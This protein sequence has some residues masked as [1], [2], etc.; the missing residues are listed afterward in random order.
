MIPK[1][2]TPDR[3]GRKGATA[4]NSGGAA[5]KAYRWIR[6]LLVNGSFQ[7]GSHLREEL[8]ASRLGVS[9]TPVRE[10]VRRLA[11]EGW[12][13]I[14]P[15]QGAYVCD[16]SRHDVEEVFA[17]RAMLEGYAAEW[18]ARNATEA[19]IETL[20]QLSARA[21]S[22]LPGTSA[23]DI[24]QIAELNDRFHK[25][26]LEASGQRRT[27]VTVTHLVELPITLRNF[28]Q[29]TAADMQRSVNQHQAVVEAIAARDAAWAGAVM[30]A[31]VLSGKAIFME[32]IGLSPGSA[33]DPADAPADDITGGAVLAADQR[34]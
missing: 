34:R 29:F 11:A 30:R 22:L 20:R 32:R 23:E 19:Q 4:R 15:N 24:E 21:T 28:H 6:S 3:S 8:L 5:D 10:A 25:L 16:W 9:R 14:I 7:A 31:H 12:L 2:S 17:L 27:A 13:S 1:A 33:G 26:I 18:A